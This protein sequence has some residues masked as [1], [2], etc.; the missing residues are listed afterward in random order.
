MGFSSENL[1][2]TGC[3]VFNFISHN[4]GPGQHFLRILYF[5]YLYFFV[6]QKF[7]TVQITVKDISTRQGVWDSAGG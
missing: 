3:H 2:N 7:I 4:G 5:L 1:N 6:V